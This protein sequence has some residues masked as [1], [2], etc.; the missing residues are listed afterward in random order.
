MNGNLSTTPRVI[1]IVHLEV[2]IMWRFMVLAAAMCMLSAC[3]GPMPWYSNMPRDPAS[4]TD[5]HPVSGPTF[6]IG[7]GPKH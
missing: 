2:T 1:W 3:G 4:V 7:G 6:E 5:T